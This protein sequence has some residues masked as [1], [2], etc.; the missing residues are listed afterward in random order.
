MR[1]RARVSVIDSVWFLV[2]VRVSLKGKF[3]VLHKLAYRFVSVQ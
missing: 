2:R 3:A 1:A